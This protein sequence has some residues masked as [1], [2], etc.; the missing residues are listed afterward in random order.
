MPFLML[1]LSGIKSSL[2][3]NIIRMDSH[4]VENRRVVLEN[5]MVER[6]RSIYKENEYLSSAL[7]QILTDH[8]SDIRQFL[9]SKDMQQEYLEEVFPDMV[10]ELQYNTTSGVF[11]ILANDDPIAE[12]AKYR[13]FFVRDSDPQAKV[14]SNA[15]LLL[16]R[17]NKQLS[18][19]LAI[20]LDSAWTTDFNFAGQGNRSADDFFYKPYTAALEHMDTDMV[21]MGYWAKPF[22]LEDHYM[23][24]HHM[25]TYSVPLLY[26]NTIYGVVG[27]EIAVS[28]L[29]SYFSVKDLDSALNAGYAL[30][31]EHDDNEY[32][33]ITGKGA[34]YDAVSRED[35][36][37]T[38]TKQ[39]K[40]ELYQVKGAQIG[41]QDIYAIIEPLD[42]YSNNVPYEDTKWVLCGFVTE[43]SV[44]GM[45]ESVYKRM[46]FAILACALFA[47]VFVYLL[48]RY[49]TKPVY[50]LMQCVRGG[51]EG[52]HNFRR[53]DILEIDELHDVVENLTDMQKRTEEQLLEEKERYRIAVESSQDMFFMFRRK[54][55]ILEIVNS[56]GYDGTWDCK[57]H[58]EFI[59]N[60]CI[61]PEDKERV[62][63]ALLNPTKN[64]DVDFRLRATDQDEY[65]WVNLSGSILW[66]GTGEDSRIVGCVSNIHQRKLLEEAQKNSQYYDPITSFYRLLYGEEAI[67]KAWEDTPDGVLA[68][69]DIEKFAHVN[70]HYGLVFG[71]L[72][73]QQLAKFIVAQC[74]TAGLKDVIYVRAGADQMLLWIPGVE[75][76]LVRNV[77]DEVRHN[78][79]KLT[80]E[81]Y[82][83]LN[84]RCGIVQTKQDV[85]PDAS[86]RQGQ[87]AL[88]LA[89]QG[90]ADTVIYENLSERE[91]Q[92]SVEEP[93]D[94]VDSVER[95][96]QMSLSSLALNLFDRGGEVAVVLD[97]LALKLQE[98]YGITNLVITY[99]NPEYDANTVWYQWKEA[100]Y[101]EGWNGVLHCTDEQYRQFEE[102]E[103]LQETCPFEQGTYSEE[104][105]ILGKII[106][107]QYGVLFHMKDNGKYSGSILFMGIPA[108]LL[109]QEIEKK[110]FDEVGSI[111]Q[112][113]I[114]LQIHDR[115]A[116]AKSDF[117]ARM[118]HEIRTP[119][120][121]IM[122]MTEIAL[123]DGQ[124][125]EQRIN[126]L[127]KI[128]NSS[129]YLLGLLND[130]L[131]MSK[132]ESGK[133]KLVYDKHSLRKMI[134]GLGTL[135][136]A[137]IAE[138]NIHFTQ[139]IHL[140]HEWFICD[141]LRIN[142]VLVNLL[143][144]A[145][146]YSNADGNICLTVSETCVE[147]DRSEVYFSV[148]D[149]G[150]G[151]PEDKQH[152]IF[153]QFEQVDDSERARRQGTGLGL[154]IC[155][156][157]IHMM[158]SEVQVQSKVGEGSTFYFTIKLEP[159][160]EAE[161][162]TR[163][164]KKPVDL[165]GKRVLVVEDNL[166]NMEIICT[167]LE[168]YQ[169]LVEKV[170]DGSEAVDKM[171]D[172]DPGY[173]DL[174]LMDIMM[175]VM[176]GLEA[177]REI[178]KLP[179]E[180][181]RTIPIIAMSANAFD[182]DVKRSL[183]SGMNGHLSKPV[184]IEK[185]EEMLSNVLE[186]T[187]C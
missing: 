113:R 163:A 22:V 174:I 65:Q 23:D 171:R 40:S 58:P 33:R 160:D 80:N 4:T 76:E 95:L 11:L 175:P 170:Y 117:L 152:L 172:T 60:D 77:V 31:I 98:Q 64:L 185:L 147:N 75:A 78:F 146:K 68:L 183:A 109:E 44:Y 154:A 166:L 32:E 35:D 144:N 121:G 120:N 18:H 122:G 158:D 128:K 17:G 126:C 59:D 19:N 100:E 140:T 145:V 94:E 12:E 103:T 104:S 161:M 151:I 180:D 137:K 29:N 70:E 101:E 159:V 39:A 14:A 114:N 28:Y 96:K 116:Q 30:M 63:H 155:S 48:V 134:D 139:E 16:E 13:G 91:R 72:I 156:R 74:K 34:L 71:D 186:E 81:N 41:K 138:K 124:T 112:N 20:S 167:L 125:E 118:S 86:R 153:Q 131:D 21:N 27:V 83:A 6:W 25:I 69:I 173:Y 15:D 37:L 123:K 108:Q 55:R 133:M 93:L 111:I 10:N 46:L 8:E 168:E 184:N 52:I 57:E 54:D 53:S 47:T 62:Y 110:R 9:G 129:N 127:K 2:E 106:R 42:L 150:I 26:D 169:I 187:E 87:I 36:L 97:I 61:Y 148:A 143:G 88:A 178:R 73:L 105:P 132:I 142:Q 56:D 136:E 182:E 92:V 162:T 99:F 1:V 89:K 43:D 119:M 141:E 3:N 67:R 45:G 135:M 107:G 164:H 50:H 177:T 115:S 49:V 149:D 130:I 84:I 7:E 5:D 90:K 165:H 85:L 176:D 157:L 82:L 79:A 38:L 51:V 102:R 179:R 24:S 181:C 66:D